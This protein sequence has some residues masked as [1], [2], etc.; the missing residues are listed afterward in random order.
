M[1]IPEKSPLVSPA[2]EEQLKTLFAKLQRE[3]ELCAILGDDE[4]S[5]EMGGF[6]RHIASLC[7]IR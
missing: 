6:L 2:L 4:K 5:R 3:V 7:L 1:V